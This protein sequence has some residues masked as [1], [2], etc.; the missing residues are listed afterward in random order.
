MSDAPITFR[1]PRDVLRFIRECLNDNDMDR[2]YNAAVEP[3]SD[4]WREHVFNDL[5]EIESSESL[6]RV[7]LRWNF[8][9][10]RKSKYK[11]GGHSTRTRHLHID[12]IRTEEGW[13]LKT[14]WKCR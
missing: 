3:T 10:W 5:R 4:F 1:R 9:P 12:L 2:L 8:F 7:F 6:E 13:R 11:L 14:I